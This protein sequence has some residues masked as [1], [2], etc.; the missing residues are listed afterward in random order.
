[1]R[2]V[3]VLCFVG[4]SAHAQ[5][6]RV[7]SLLNLLSSAK[8]DTVRL[9]LLDA[10]IEDQSHDYTL[11]EKYSN[12]MQAVSKAG[13]GSASGE[14]RE[15]YLR[16]Y[17]TALNNLAYVEENKGN[18][19]GAIQKYEQ[20][21]NIFKENNDRGGEAMCLTNLGFVSKKTGDL[22]KAIEYYTKSLAINKETANQSGT[23]ASMNNLGLTFYAMGDV[24]KAQAYYFEGL[25]IAEEMGD[26]RRQ[27]RMLNN[28]AGAYFSQNEITLHV[29]YLEKSLAM[30]IEAG[31]KRGEATIRA[32]LVPVFIKQKQY[33]KA[34]E[35]AEKVLQMGKDLNDKDMFANGLTVM[36]KVSR[37][38]GRLQEA[39]DY[40]KQGLPIKQALGNK[41]N[42][43]YTLN[44]LGGISAEMKRYPDAIRYY[45]E[46]MTISQQIG[47]PVEISNVARQL[48]DVYKQMGN[49]AKAFELYELHIKMR[50]SVTNEDNRKAALKSQYKYEYEIKATSDSVRAESEKAVLSAQLDQATSQRY[51]LTAAVILI[52]TM[53]SFV[54]Y[55]FRVTQQVK[56]LQLRNKIASDLHDEVGSAISSISLFAGMAK[57]KSGKDTEDIVAKIENTSRET[58]NNMSDIVWSIEPSNDRFDNVLRKMKYFG[59]QI[60]GTL[61]I[62]FNLAYEEGIEKTAFDMS[63]RKNIYLIFKEALNNAVKYSDAK[64]VE[65]LL[66]KDGRHYIMEIKDDGKGFDTTTS[67][68]GNGLRNMKRRAEELGGSLAINSTSAGTSITLRV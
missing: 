36:A 66:S 24:K 56:E 67:T 35:H 39:L 44:N 50:D 4:A 10:I 28:I 46:S 22:P 37:A 59:E 43:I 8:H 21:L 9:H 26:K 34:R 53:A 30:A 51:A 1:M 19:A 48:S 64:N 61:N 15:F 11:V 38:D 25:K 7:D 29:E 40:E 33:E 31:E 45:N 47:S 42:Y 16:H 55:R 18:N 12:E 63:K 62:G 49:T 54:F 14:L 2:L 68:L 65:V 60:T 20:A 5:H 57:L 58:V 3:L 23:F 52:I 17:A 13:A 27:A 41:N 6:G 32:N